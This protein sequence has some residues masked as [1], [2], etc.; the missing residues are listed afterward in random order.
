VI[1]AIP[2]RLES[3]NRLQP[4][5]SFH[6]LYV[7]FFLLLGGLIGEYWLRTRAWRWVALFIPLAL[8]MAVVQ[9]ST[10]PASRHVEWPGLNNGNAWISAFLWIRSNTP[11]EAVFALDPD[12]MA[13]PGEDTHGFRAVAERSVL[14]DSLKDSA[15]VTLFPKLA[16]EWDNQ[17]RA[18]RGLDG[19]DAADFQKLVRRYPVTWI[20]TA[21]PTPPWLTC[22]YRN[23]DLAVCRI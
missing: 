15:A 7:I 2:E 12:Y 19:F 6:L 9:Q 16:A 5:R 10:F 21:R 13:A 3:F 22:P 23:G 11:E 18:G 8:V 14:A 17:V 20:L 4:M 1:L